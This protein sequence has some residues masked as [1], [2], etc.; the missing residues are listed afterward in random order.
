MRRI[1]YVAGPMMLGSMAHNIAQAMAAGAKLIEAGFTPILPQLSFFMSIQYEQTWE[2]WLDVDK[3]LVLKSSAVLRLPGESRGA[4]LEVKWADEAGIPVFYDIAELVAHSPGQPPP[5]PTEERPVWYYVIDDMHERSAKNAE[6]NPDQSI[7]DLVIEDMY[8]RDDLGRKRYGTPLQVSNG[9]DP[10]ADA[11][12][13]A[14]DGAAYLKQA[15]LRGLPI[16]DLYQKQV[17][18][19]LGIRALIEAERRQGR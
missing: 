15:Y 17:A 14:L 13:E 4:D 3:P 5:V 10:L 19:V 12:D 2:T 16:G 6:M 9:R 8:A 11:Y 18:Q 1:I 7:V